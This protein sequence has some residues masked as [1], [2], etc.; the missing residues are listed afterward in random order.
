M[1]KTFLLCLILT[2]SSFSYFLTPFKVTTKIFNSENIKVYEPLNLDTNKNILFFTGA[3]SFIPGEVYSSF[4]S[5]VAQYNMT[6][7]VCSNNLLTCND[8]YKTI[9]NTD[10][11]IVVGHSTGCM[12]AIDF[13]N[14][15]PNVKKIVLMDAVDNS[16][17]YKQKYNDIPNKITDNLVKRV[18]DSAKILPFFK[19]INYEA[20]EEDNGKLS[21]NDIDEVMFLNARKSYTWDLLDKKFPFIPAFGIHKNTI[22]YKN[23]NVNEIIIVAEEFGHTDILDEIWANNM[24]NTIS[25]GTEDRSSE[26]LSLYHKWLATIIYIFAYNK[27][28]LEVLTKDDI[29]K[30]IKSKCE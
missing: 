26:N 19:R 12:N 1:F 25:R 28:S 2:T 30:Q 9:E 3:N 13:C 7:Y 4:L 8:I 18:V 6:T 21:L 27:N 15:N 14:N 16:Y 23:N 11:T 20:T 22:E 29:V 10:E 24:H 17:L 5:N